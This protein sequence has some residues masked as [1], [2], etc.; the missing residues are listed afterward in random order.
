MGDLTSPEGADLVRRA[1][2]AW[3][4][5]GVDHLAPFLADDVSVEDAPEL[6]DAGIWNGSE[7]VLRRLEEV[8]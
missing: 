7:A 4:W 6:P 8:G 5:Y 2:D 1:Y 3:N